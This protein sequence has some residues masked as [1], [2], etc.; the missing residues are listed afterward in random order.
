M[1]FLAFAGD[2]ILLGTTNMFRFNN[3]TEA[4]VLRKKRMVSIKVC[5]GF[6]WLLF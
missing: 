3:P 2:V 5:D 1:I 4:A 6:D